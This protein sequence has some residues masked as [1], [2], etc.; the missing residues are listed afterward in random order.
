MPILGICS[1]SAAQHN[2]YN[3]IAPLARFLWVLSI[4]TFD[5]MAT[6]IL[7]KLLYSLLVLW[8]VVSVT[9]YI[10]SILP[11][12]PARLMLGQRADIVSLEALRHQ[13]GLDRPLYEQYVGFIAKAAQGDLGRSFSTNLDVADTIIERFPATALLAVS[14]M[15]LATILGVLIGVLSSLRPN[16]W[17]D[18]AAMSTSLLGISVPSFVMGL[19]FILFFASGTFLD[20]FPVSGYI[21]RGW[22]HLLLP[23]ITLGVRP[24]SI[25][26]R[27][28]RSSMLDVLGQDY[29]RTARAKGL[30]KAVVVAKHAL[31]NALNPIVT[32]VSSWFAAL[33]AGTFFIEFVFNWPGIGSAAINAIQKL[34]Y[35][36]IQG[37]VLFTAI[38]FVVVNLLVDIIYVFLDPKVKLQ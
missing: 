16:S 33:L 1:R 4:F 26:A 35:P 23:M 9:F 28:T 17:F 3:G 37:V 36:M 22:Q 29:V 20:W 24:L 12:D 30:S 27:V 38:T 2:S 15:L 21:D 10:T 31:R 14:S 5:T 25:I 8:G 34:D 32:T 11:G 13:M 6:F 18:T 19:L 7:R